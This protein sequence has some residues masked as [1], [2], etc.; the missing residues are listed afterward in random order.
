MLVDGLTTA[1]ISD[2]IILILLE[3]KAVPE[4]LPQTNFISFVVMALIDSELPKDV[5]GISQVM[6]T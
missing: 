4:T 5:H 1:P 6:K 2:E 3:V